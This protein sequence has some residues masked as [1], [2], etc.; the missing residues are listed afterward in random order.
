MKTEKQNAYND[1]DRK[2]YY[3]TLNRVV[4]DV[5]GMTTIPTDHHGTIGKEYIYTIG[6]DTIPPSFNSTGLRSLQVLNSIPS[7][8]QQH[9][10]HNHSPS[11]Y[12]LR[13]NHQVHVQYDNP[14]MTT[15]LDVDGT[16]RTNV[17]TGQHQLHSYLPNGNVVS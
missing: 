1:D 8:Q 2:M 13:S 9:V 12:S 6:S 4:Q 11:H 7:H 15:H 14:A 5:T 16:G 10:H 3:S 17:T